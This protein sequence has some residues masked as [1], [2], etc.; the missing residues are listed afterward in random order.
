M[1][2]EWC[3][4]VFCEWTHGCC[5]KAQPFFAVNDGRTSLFWLIVTTEF[6]ETSKAA[7]IFHANNIGKT[8]LRRVGLRGECHDSCRSRKTAGEKNEGSFVREKQGLPLSLETSLSTQLVP[9]TPI[10][11][12]CPKFHPSC[13]LVF[14]KWL[15]WACKMQFRQ[16]YAKFWDRI[17]RKFRWSSKKLETWLLFSSKCSCG[18]IECSFDEPPDFFCRKSKILRL[19]IQKEIKCSNFFSQMKYQDT[20]KA[21]PTELPQLISYKF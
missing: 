5:H 8:R 6:C 18:E 11:E 7:S 20:Y 12:I 2:D 3:W 21:V 4:S 17:C 15:L 13:P 9:W 16:T 19:I 14:F 1:G 10:L